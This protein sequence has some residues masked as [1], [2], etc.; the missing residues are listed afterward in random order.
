MPQTHWETEWEAQG[1]LHREE[2]LRGPGPQA[3]PGRQAVRSSGGC[4]D[5]GDLWG[6]PSVLSFSLCLQETGCRG[7]A[8]CSWRPCSRCLRVGRKQTGGQ[9]RRQRSGQICPGLPWT[10]GFLGH[11]LSGLNLAELLA[12]QDSWSSEP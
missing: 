1:W 8:A 3:A 10:E 5:G 12:S 11:E 9:I 6:T 7:L 4:E 2:T